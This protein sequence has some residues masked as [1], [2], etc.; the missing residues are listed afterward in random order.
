MMEGWSIARA[1]YENPEMS[2]VVGKVDITN[3]PVSE[4]MEPKYGFGGWGIGINAASDP[5]KQEAAW[6]FIKWLTSAE[7]QKEW[8]LHRWCSH[9]PSTL[10]DPEV[11][12]AMSLV[13]SAA[14]TPLKTAMVI[15]VHVSH[16][17]ALL[18]MHWVLMSTLSWLDK[19][20]PRVLW[21]KP[22]LKLRK[23]W[24]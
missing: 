16:S 15:I 1:G 10:E 14:Q 6:E 19:K 21:I 13:P 24:K 3:A 18:K 5:K 8:V 2:K 11:V 20:L 23:H 4:G 22:R 12:K 17:T 7:I 9:S